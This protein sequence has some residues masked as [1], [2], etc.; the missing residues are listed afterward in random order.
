MEGGITMSRIEECTHVE[1]YEV[2]FS[3]IEL[4]GSK[5][6][7]CLYLT[8]VTKNTVVKRVSISASNISKLMKVSDVK[9]IGELNRKTIRCLINPHR[10]IN[11]ISFIEDNWIICKDIY[12]PRR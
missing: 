10:E 9:S 6:I 8:N 2:A 12:I 3:D 11:Y 1:L 7:L 4:I 5:F